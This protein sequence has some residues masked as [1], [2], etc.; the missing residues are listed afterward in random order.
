MKRFFVFIFIIIPAFVFT[1]SQ[2]GFGILPEIAANYS[3]LGRWSVTSKVE[4]MHFLYES[5]NNENTIKHSY[6]QTDIQ[7]F[8]NYKLAIALRVSAGYQYRIQPGD[9]SHRIIQQITT[10]QLFNY[11]RLGHRL[12]FDESFY[13]HD[14]PQ[15]RARYRLSS[16]IALSGSKLDVREYYLKGSIEAIYSLQN[17]K[18]EIEGRFTLM[19]GHYFPNRHK[20]EAGFDYRTDNYIEGIN[21]HNLWF[22]IGYFFNL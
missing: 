19:L 22:K 4:S 1:Q 21:N 7:V 13:K 12:R 6:D 5:K 3:N 20:M 8:G 10:N 15:F 17:T 9:N 2:F 16:E 11:I 18:Q 14:R